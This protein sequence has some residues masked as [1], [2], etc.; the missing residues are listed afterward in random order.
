MNMLICGY[1]NID[2]IDKERRMAKLKD[3]AKLA[4]VSV[5]TVSRILNNDT[6]LSVTDKTKNEVLNAARQ[7]NYPIKQKEKRTTFAIIQW[8]SQDQEI[9]DPYYL[10]LRRGA[11]SFLKKNNIAVR[12]FFHDDLDMDSTLSQI[13]G[14]LCLGKFSKK[15]IDKLKK[16]TQ[17]IILLD[18]TLYPCREVSIVLDFDDAVKQV[19]QYLYIYGS[20]KKSAI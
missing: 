9:S 17:R 13:D 16:Y 4:N 18:M 1:K 11:E 3:V 8:F 2:N 12:R 14:I 10:T 19:I 20:Q 15:Y 5:S 6:S 7:L